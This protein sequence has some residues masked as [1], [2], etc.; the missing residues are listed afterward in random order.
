MIT[1]IDESCDPHRCVEGIGAQI[2]LFTVTQEQDVINPGRG[3]A[4]E[5]ALEI[6]GRI[7]R[8]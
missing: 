8:S 6:P 1:Y 7:P 5:D 3:E 2:V 4:V